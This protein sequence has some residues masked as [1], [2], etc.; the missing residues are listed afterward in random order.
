MNEHDVFASLGLYLKKDFLDASLCE[1]MRAR[2][3]SDPSEAGYIKTLERGESID[4]N[5]RRTRV[6]QVPVEYAYIIRDRLEE[7]K[8]DLESRFQR[9]LTLQE[10]PQFLL[11]EPG[12]YYAPHRDVPTEQVKSAAR[13]K[14]RIISIVVFLNSPTGPHPYSGGELTF[15]ELVSDPQWKEYGLTL[16]A[17]AGLLVAFHSGTLHEVRPVTGGKRYTITTWFH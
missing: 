15:Y 1:E 10:K 4:L 17:E 7:L 2:M 16:E 5:V 9:R 14:N 11:Y 6:V 8:P 3:E 13:I 12:S